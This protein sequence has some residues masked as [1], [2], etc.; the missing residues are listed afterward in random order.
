MVLRLRYLFS[1]D[2]K[3]EQEKEL[4]NHHQK[5]RCCLKCLS[6]RTVLRARGAENTQN[7]VYRYLKEQF[8]DPPRRLRP[9]PWNRTVNRTPS[10][11]E[12]LKPE[13]DPAP[14]TKTVCPTPTGHESSPP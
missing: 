2:H 13:S 5:P 3:E 10:L 7:K 4:I 11:R 6:A 14:E 8:H 1:Y 12:E 9:Q